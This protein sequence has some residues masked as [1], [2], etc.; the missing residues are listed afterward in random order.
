MK[1]GA[2]KQSNKDVEIKTAHFRYAAKR[3]GSSNGL[4]ALALH[5]WLDN[6]ASFDHLAPFLPELDLVALDFPGHGYSAHRPLGIRYHYMDYIADVINV[7]DALHWEK[8]ILMGHSLGGGVASF[9]AGAL[10]DRISKLILIEGLGA[11]SRQP[12]D[13]PKFLAKSIVQMQTVSKK[14]PPVYTNKK[15]IINARAK[16]GDME[17]KSVET[18]VNRGIVAL[19][20]GIT[21]RSDP[22]LRVTSPSYLTDE[23]VFAFL[24]AITAPVLLILGD[25]GIF[26][27]RNYLETRCDKIKNLRQHVLHGS[28]HLHLDN[29]EPVSELI[30]N[31]LKEVD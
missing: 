31:F 21:W 13:A 11:M 17:M 19:E 18:L 20:D 3:W 25:K 12:Q 15:E 29:P 1:N 22:R 6:A 26:S 2:S 14:L 10:P 24:S 16:V 4:P 30:H 9:T 7:A 27:D 5:G 23:Q 28:H 8:F